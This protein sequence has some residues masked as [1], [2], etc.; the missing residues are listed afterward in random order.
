MSSIFITRADN[1]A[2]LTA[3]LSSRLASCPLPL[4]ERD[5][6]II[7]IGRQKEEEELQRKGQQTIYFNRIRDGINYR[8]FRQGNPEDD[9]KKL[10]EEATD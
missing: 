6:H 8:F 3:F 1:I 4:S 7:L 10:K 2:P 5:S 9:D